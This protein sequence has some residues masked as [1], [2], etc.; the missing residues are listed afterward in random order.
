MKA[1]SDIAVLNL[2]HN[3]GTAELSH[4]L[5]ESLQSGQL[6]INLRAEGDPQDS[7]RSNAAND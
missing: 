6:I 1:L 3:E 7:A 5:Q 4:S 2:V